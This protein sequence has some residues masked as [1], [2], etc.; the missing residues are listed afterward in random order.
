MVCGQGFTYQAIFSDP[1]ALFYSLYIQRDSLGL[2]NRSRE[3]T[4]RLCAEIKPICLPSGVI[5]S[6]GRSQKT[7]TRSA[8]HP[9]KSERSELS[10]L[11]C[12][13]QKYIRTEPF[14]V[15]ALYH[16]STEQFGVSKRVS[17]NGGQ[18]ESVRFVYTL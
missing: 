15:H 16:E 1:K 2:D 3:R 10:P 6:M 8:P 9:Q 17:A 13:F 14:K 18:V 12:P 11:P 4:E 5:L 7:H